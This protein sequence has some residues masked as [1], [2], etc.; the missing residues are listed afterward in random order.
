MSAAESAGEAGQFSV[1]NIEGARQALN[2]QPLTVRIGYQ[3]P[4]PRLA[5]TVGAI[6]QA[7]A[8]AGITVT[9][10]AGDS[11]GPLSLR[12]N[13]HRRAHREH[14]R[15]PRQR[16]DGFVEPGRLRPAHRQRQQPVR[17]QQ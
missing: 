13:T 5:A 7:C 17:L 16:L 1:A 2:N 10:A 6:A 4:N 15:R 12:D 11:V 9:E 3:S 14:R 8:P